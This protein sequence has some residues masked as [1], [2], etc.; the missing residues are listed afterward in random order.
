[1]TSSERYADANRVLSGGPLRWV[2]WEPT[3]LGFA[4]LAA[5]DQQVSRALRAEWQQQVLDQ[6]WDEGQ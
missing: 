5:V 4:L 6:R 2:L 3:S 1:M